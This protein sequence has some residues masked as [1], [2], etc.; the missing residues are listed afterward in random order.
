[1]IIK[2]SKLTRFEVS[3]AKIRK[4]GNFARLKIVIVDHY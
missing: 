2:S 1:M 4:L 3:F